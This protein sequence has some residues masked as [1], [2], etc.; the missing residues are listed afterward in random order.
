[1]DGRRK[2]NTN[3]LSGRIA[4]IEIRER[5]DDTADDIHPAVYENQTGVLGWHATILHRLEVNQDEWIDGDDDL[6]ELDAVFRARME[7][8]IAI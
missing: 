1:M 6:K 2:H 5:T 7:K 4:D 8:S 3:T